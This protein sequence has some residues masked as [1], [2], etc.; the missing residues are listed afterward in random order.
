VD[1]IAT[2]GEQKTDDVAG[3]DVKKCC[4]TTT[5]TS[6]T[7]INITIDI[8]T[9]NFTIIIIVVSNGITTITA[10]IAS[11]IAAAPCTYYLH[12]DRPRSERRFSSP[13]GRPHL[14][15]F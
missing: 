12:R 13:R 2:T 8:N 15:C 1:A 5:T 10:F 6:G 9:I 14:Q 3:R 11:P 4:L 7:T